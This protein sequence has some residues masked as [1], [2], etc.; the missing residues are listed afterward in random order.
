MDVRC[1]RCRAQY[2]FDDDQVTPAGLTVQCTNCGH[3]FRVKK[4]ELVVTVP[5]KPDEIDG[6]PL[7]ASAARR[8]QGPTSGGPGDSR[9]PAREWRVR[10]ANGNIFTFRELTTLQKWII[11]QK[12]SRDDEISSSRGE[13]WKR[14]GNIADLASFFQVVEAAERGRAVP[15]VTPVGVTGVPGFAL[16]P[17]GS[18]TLAYPPPPSGHP[19]PAFTTPAPAP[20][21][22]ASERRAEPLP[23]APG[24]DVDL[25]PEELAAVKKGRGARLALSAVLLVVAGGAGAY[26]LAP[27]LFAAPKPQ[28][29]AAEVPP[30]T[31]EVKV[32][33]RQPEPAPAAEPPPAPVPPVA[34]PEPIVERAIEPPPAPVT[35]PPKPPAPRGPKALLA[36]ASRLREKGDVEA[37]LDLYG[38]VAGDDPENVEALTGRGLCYL[39]LERWPP[40]EASFQAALQVDPRQ[41]DALLGLAET[42]RWQGKKADA[43]RY[44]ERYLAANPQ[45]EEAH[46]ARNALEELR[47]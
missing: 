12:V 28:G 43:I 15:P 38:R 44:Y 20:R 13:P 26:V 22:P 7:P 45:G 3:V 27:R 17:P 6:P 37:A 16:P 24:V 11:E 23:A 30:A 21:G 41:P 19:P 35:A 32:E 5:V 25:A 47:K 14:L 29:P 39:D 10:Q 1:E 4:K 8:P 40:A 46:V 34:A 18:T 42:Y 33:Q 9:E 31:L 36:Q 2:V